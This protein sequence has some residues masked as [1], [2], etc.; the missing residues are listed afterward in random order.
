[1]NQSQRAK[2]TIHWLGILILTVDI[3]FLLS[4]Q[5][6]RKVLFT[7]LA[8]LKQHMCSQYFCFFAQIFQ[9]AHE[10]GSLANVTCLV[11]N[12]NN[13]NNQLYL[14]RVTRDSKN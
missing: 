11:Y 5:S 10:Y 4:N 1:M 9:A 12:N 13:N 2:N 8:I 7:C 3:Y 14:G 6:A